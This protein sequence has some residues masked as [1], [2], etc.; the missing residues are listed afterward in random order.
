VEIHDIED[1]IR[2]LCAK[3]AA[4]DEDEAQEILPELN[5]ALRQH[6]DFLRKITAKTLNLPPRKRPPPRTDPT[7]KK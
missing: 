3:A 2:E 7:P 6:S 4:A 5:K 1:R